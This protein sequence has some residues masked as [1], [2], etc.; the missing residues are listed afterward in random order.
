VDV[1]LVG[2]GGKFIRALDPQSFNIFEERFF[3]LRCEF[4]ERDASFTR[5]TDR[6]I[7]HIGDVHHPMHLVTAQFEMALKQ[8]FKNVGPKISYVRPTIN[9]RPASVDTDGVVGWVARFELFDLT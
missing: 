9:G 7:V 3:E 1:T 2:R 8:I 5:T 6:F 4:C